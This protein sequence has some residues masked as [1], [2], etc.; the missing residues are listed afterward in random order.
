MSVRPGSRLA[1]ALAG[2]LAGA[3]RLAWAGPPGSGE[4]PDDTRAQTE[5]LDPDPDSDPD[6]EA[7]ADQSEPGDDA[8]DDDRSTREI[9]VSS[10]TPD[11]YVR[12]ASVVSRRQ[13]Q[14][15]L[16]RSAPDALRFEPGVYVQQS[17]HAQASPYV[18][19]L[20]G[21]QTL[22]AFDGI[23]LN[24]STFRQGPN[25]YFF[26]VDSRTIQRLEVVRGA[27][28]T[29]WGSDALGGALLTTPMDPTMDRSKR[30]TVHPRLLLAHRTADGE[31]GGRA[32]LDLGWKGKLGFFGGVGYRDVGQLRTSGAVTAPATGRPW[33]E[34]RFA[35][36][37]RTQLGTGFREL[38][39][40][41][42]L[43]WQIDDRWRLSAGYYDYRQKDAPRTDKCPPAEAPDDECLVYLDQF[44]TL[45]YL[46]ADMSDGPDAAARARV[47]VSYQN[48]H[49]RTQLTRDNGVPAIDG[50]IESNGRDDVHT[51]G[52]RT[53]LST[54]VLPLGERV[55][56]GVDY[57]GDLYFDM[58]ESHAW[59]EFTDVSP[60]VTSVAPRGQYIDGSRYLTSGV[61]AQPYVWI[62]E[63]VR[64]RAGGR[65]AFVW[66]KADGEDASETLAVDRSWATAV[67]NA[68]L[69]VVAAPWLTWHLDFDQGFRAPNLDD[70]TSRQQTGPGFQFE[71]ASLEPERALSFDTGFRVRHKRVEASLFVWHSFIRGLIGRAPRELGACPGGAAENPTGCEAS[72][73][74]FQLVNLDGWALLR[75]VDSSVRVF[76]PAG[77]VI[78][79]TFSWAW[80]EGQNP[81]PPPTNTGASNYEERLPLSRVPPLNGTVELTW[82]SNV[83]LWL[84]SALRWAGTQDRLALADVADTRIPDGGTPGFAVWD[85]RAGYRFDPVVLLGLV[86][87]NV[88]DSP[89]RYH[90]SS[91]NGATRSLNL[92]VEVGF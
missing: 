81:V 26:T 86:F 83:G 47:S 61:W 46:A 40:D 12:D 64:I 33:K 84:G 4:A 57:G 21:Q 80:G 54:A 49:E 63:R 72:R 55:A 51:L 2:L 15:R 73:T 37:E 45:T 11:N 28:S 75:G 16:P 3:S 39:A 24:T 31:L 20:T 92:S 44:R 77:F 67:G 32:Q 43:V 65:G 70:L 23:R 59:L 56:F 6:P 85:L 91:V 88:I 1:A 38:T 17:A 60:P 53:T 8:A 79:A 34:P 48:Q 25:Q 69:M 14:E 52:L 27:A 87:E 13:I 9:I 19:G 36:D 35:S 22:I 68:G 30:W 71:N 76:I 10:D 29:T 74:R 50:G 42:R 82:Y 66:A 58:I 78:G 62:G 41:A 18:R 90:G 89:H 7:D 5:D